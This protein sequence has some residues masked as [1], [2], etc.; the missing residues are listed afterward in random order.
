MSFT[1]LCHANYII[2]CST[3][4]L[5]KPIASP[6]LK[7]FPAFYTY[8][9]FITTFTTARHLPLS[10]VASIQYTQYTPHHTYW[11][12]ILVL[13][14]HMRPDVKSG[15]FPSG[16]TTKTP[17]AFLYSIRST[18]PAHLIRSNLIFRLNMWCGVQV[19]KF[20]VMQSSPV[21][22]YLSL[23]NP[24]IF[25]IILLSK[26]LQPKFRLQCEIP[27]FTPI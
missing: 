3:V 2:P 1:K 12:Y 7:T 27:N 10:W 8:L 17:Y 6:F 15:L 19:M 22:C 5:E 25:L 4:L 20:F 23:L 18:R 11:R 21:P 13:F 9:S 14:S 24:N 26:N 16:F